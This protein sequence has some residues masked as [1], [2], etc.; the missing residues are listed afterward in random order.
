MCGGAGLDAHQA[1]L[2][3]FP[4]HSLLR[5][6]PDGSTLQITRRTPGGTAE[7]TDSR[8][9]RLLSA[10]SQ[11]PRCNRASQCDE[12]PSPHSRPLSTMTGKDHQM[13]SHRASGNC[14]PQ[15][16]HPAD[17]SCLISLVSRFDRP[18]IGVRSSFNSGHSIK[19]RVQW[20]L[21]PEAEAPVLIAPQKAFE[22]ELDA[23]LRS[24]RRRAICPMSIPATSTNAT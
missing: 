18:L 16:A 4:R 22:D 20:R 1:W 2:G 10:P 17:S 19:R 5:S 6:V 11:W 14:S 15:S 23:A 3:S 12:L 8:V 13:I 9:Q 24:L 7:E 21:V